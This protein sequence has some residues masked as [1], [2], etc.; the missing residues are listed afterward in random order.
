MQLLVGEFQFTHDGGR[1]EVRVQHYRHADF[2][3]LLATQLLTR[4]L[5]RGAL[6][7]LANLQVP[8]A[9]HHD[10][11]ILVASFVVRTGYVMQYEPVV[12][13]SS[14]DILTYAY[15]LEKLES[16]PSI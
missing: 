1:A 12:F 7:I 15:V 16:Y 14:W 3:V 13:I 9:L 11:P 8:V 5:E 10:L 2:S 4:V 6:G